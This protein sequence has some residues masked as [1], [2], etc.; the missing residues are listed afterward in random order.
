MDNL[1][2]MDKFFKRYNLPRLNQEEIENMNRPIT[3]NEIDTVIK[4]L[5]TN[6]VQDQMASQVKSIKHLEKS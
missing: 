2:Q 4:N 6:K 5:P 3:S 1:E